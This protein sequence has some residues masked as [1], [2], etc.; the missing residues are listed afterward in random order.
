MSFPCLCVKAMVSDHCAVKATQNANMITHQV[1]WPTC[2]RLYTAPERTQ[3][4]TMQ[5]DPYA[6][7]G[8]KKRKKKDACVVS[9][10]VAVLLNRRKE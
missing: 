6:S 7:S 4:T 2:T 3:R 10:S 5:L 8:K 9:H 1:V